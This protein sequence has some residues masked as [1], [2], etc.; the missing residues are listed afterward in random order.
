MITTTWQIL[1]MPWA[2]EGHC[3]CL[4]RGED[5]QPVSAPAASKNSEAAAT[6]RLS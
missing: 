5:P 3:A 4:A 1:W 2:D 6:K